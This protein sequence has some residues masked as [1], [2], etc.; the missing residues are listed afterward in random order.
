[1]SIRIPTSKKRLETTKFNWPKGP[2]KPKNP[3]S[4]AFVSFGQTAVRAL[5]HQWQRIF[6]R[7]GQRH[8]LYDEARY[9]AALRRHGTPIVA[10]FDQIELGKNPYTS[11][12]KKATKA[13][14]KK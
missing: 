12:Q 7:C 1:M 11:R 4:P 13:A 14:K 8:E 9:E 6:W 10:L 2:K 5:A 3:P